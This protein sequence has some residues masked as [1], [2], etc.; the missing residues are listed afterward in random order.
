MTTNESFDRRLADWLHEE[1]EHRVPDHLD[2]VLVRTVATR[3][4]PWWSSPERWLPM[5]L[6]T[7]RP[8]LVGRGNQL[9]PLVL[10]LILGLVIA[11]LVAV[12]IGTRRSVL[13][14]FGIARNGIYVASFDGDLYSVEPGSGERVTLVGGPSYDFSPVFTRDGT[15]VVFLRSDGPLTDPAI[16]TLMT[17]RPDGTDVRAITAP[18]ESLD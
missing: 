5:D 4:R 6:T 1:A 17:A 3:Q 14:P 16:L 7:P 15:R 10:L 9:R 11:A 2:A 12:A 8:A 13:E 18:M